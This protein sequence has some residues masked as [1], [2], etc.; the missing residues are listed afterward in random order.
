MKTKISLQQWDPEL[1]RV[2]QKWADQ[3]TNVDY[4]NDQKRKDPVLFH[5]THAHRKTRK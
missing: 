3:C 2:A 5:D 4:K 1:A